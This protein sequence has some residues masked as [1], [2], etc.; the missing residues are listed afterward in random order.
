MDPAAGEY[1]FAKILWGTYGAYE[2]IE[3]HE[4]GTMS[5]AGALGSFPY[6]PEESMNAL[7]NYYRNYGSFLSGGIWFS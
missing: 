5:P 3:N 4:D 2:A 6:T 7:R 1:P